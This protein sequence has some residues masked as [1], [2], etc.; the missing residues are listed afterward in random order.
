MIIIMM[1]LMTMMMI[2]LTC[3]SNDKEEETEECFPSFRLLP[4]PAP[5]QTHMVDIVGDIMS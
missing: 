4:P 3:M 5:T 2:A 1:M